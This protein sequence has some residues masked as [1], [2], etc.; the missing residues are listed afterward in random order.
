MAT[1]LT[2]GIENRGEFYSHHYLDALLANDLKP[3][4]AQWTEAEKGTPPVRAPEKRLNGLAGKYFQARADAAEVGPRA[5][6]PAWRIAHAFHAHLLDALGYDRAPVNVRLADGTLLPLVHEVRRGGKAYLWVLESAFPTEADGDPLDHT[7]LRSQRLPG[8]DTTDAPAVALTWRELLDTRIFREEDAPTWVMFL[9]GSEVVLTH[10]FKWP[11]GQAIAFDLD[12]LYA[13]RLAT[14]FRAMAGLLHADA[15]CP[16]SGTPLHDQLDENSHKHAFAVS[17]DLREGAQQAIELLG[18]DAIRF[19]REERKRGVFG[20]S[21]SAESV[22]PRALTRECLLWLYRLIFLFY[23]ESRSDELGV[24]PMKSEAYRRGYSLESLRALE[25]VPLTTPQAQDG[26]YID[27]S[28][29]QLFRLVNHGH[30]TDRQAALA[31]GIDTVAFRIHGLRSRLFDDAET[32]IL[33]KVRFKNSVL[34]KVIELLSLSREGKHKSR[35]RISYASLGIN[36][37]GAVYE[38]LLSYSGFFAMEDL[39]EVANPKEMKRK[40]PQ[41]FFVPARLRDQYEDDELVRNADGTRRQYAKGTYLFRLAG[42][43]REKSAS[44]YTPEVLTRCLVKYTLRERIGVAPGDENWL[45]A[46]DLLTLTLCEPAMGSGAFLNEVV[47]QLAEAYLQ[48]KQAELRTED[49]D[50]PGIPADQ[51]L[52]ELQR[53]K[54]RIAACQ[55]YGVDLNP[56]AAELGK[57]SLWLNVVRPGTPAPFFDARIATGNS[58]VGARK[59]VYDVDL[60]RKSSKRTGPGWLDRAPDKVE[61]QRPDDAVYHFLVPAQGMAAFE[62]DK[63]VKG[64]LP[65]DVARIAAW[66]KGVKTTWKAPEKKKLLELSAV[67]DRLWAEHASNR[68]AA[69]AAVDQRHPVWPEPVAEARQDEGTLVRAWEASVERNGA[70]RRL[71]AVMDYWCAMWF[72]PVRESDLLPG[73]DEWLED[74]EYLLTKPPRL[75]LDESMDAQAA[76]LQ[77]VG[78][79]ARRQGFLHWEWAFPE[80]FAAGGFDVIVGNPPWVKLQWREGGVLSDFDARMEV[81]RMS[82]K[83]QSDLRASTLSQSPAMDAYLAEF[84]EFSGQKANLCDASSYAILKGVQTNL[85]KAFMVRAW[86]WLGAKGAGGLFHQTGVFED[87]RGGNL[88]EQLYRRLRLAALCKNQLK[89]FEDVHNDR[90]YSF[91]VWRGSPGDVSFR[92]ISNLYHPRTLDESLLHDGVGDVPGIKGE[93]GDWDLR[94]H[95]SR[96]VEADSATLG[97]FGQLY[98]KPGTLALEARLPVVHSAEVLSVLRKFNDAPNRLGDLEGEY[99]ATE[100]FHE[101]NQQHDGTIRRETRFPESAAEWVVSG[102][103]FYVGNPFNKTPNEGCK[104]NKDYTVIDHMMMPADYL[105]RTNYVPACGTEE[106]RRR[107]PHWNGSPV[108]DRFRFANREMVAPTGERTLAGVLLPPGVSHVHTVFSVAHESGEQLCVHAAMASSI[109]IDFLVKSTGAGHVNQY[110]TRTMPVPQANSPEAPM[111]GHRA[112]RLNCLTTHYADLWS[113]LYTLAF[114]TDTHTKPDP[115]LPDWTHLGPTWDWHTPLRSPFAR[116]QALV[117]LDALAAIALG[118]TADEL[119]LI[120]RIQFPILQQYENDTWYDRRGRIVF[121]SNSHGLPGVGLKRKDWEALR[122]PQL[123]PHTYAGVTPLPD[124]AHDALGPYEPPFDR[125]DREADMRQAY[126]EFVRRGIGPAS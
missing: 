15:L 69:L 18:N 111:L 74:L 71:K 108:T 106:Y 54:A 75:D 62:K 112:L 95:A 40:N 10:A 116:R 97:L 27:A 34:Q 33:Q 31:I 73:Q 21:D 85:Y 66:R 11:R 28:L 98:D 88:R 22:D 78:D 105:P 67:V 86:D 91:T 58:L 23:V 103:H 110:F 119:C 41:T 36:Q 35:G 43:D 50:H 46:D 6:D 72:W 121:T 96:V 32:P 49:P 38:G 45:G 59:A 118:L 115:R 1:D 51:Y 109:P 77:V 79:V 82:A 117:E 30:P 122:G 83:M 39:I 55:C 37:L 17:T 107:T 100:H 8:P 25:T 53:V 70:G 12:A 123:N 44:Y 20:S 114:N 7:P 13:R 56:L 26:T 5:P 14:A 80:V 60:L 57:V 76:R 2:F 64:L 102:P 99:F 29:R 81:R 52:L 94:G 101:T 16:A 9:G 4:L 92:Y 124:W 93:H 42:R 63:V 68:T 125:C 65:E 48:R 87:P 24:A 126:A 120:Y 19:L 84:V 113:E 3:L 47:N 104:H 61:G 89:L 90:P